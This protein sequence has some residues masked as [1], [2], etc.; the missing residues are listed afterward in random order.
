DKRKKAVG[1]AIRAG[2]K[3]KIEAM[4]TLAQNHLGA[5]PTLFDSDPLL[6]GASNGVVDLRT[7]EHR[8]S[9]RDDYIIKC[10]NADYDCNAT[11]DTWKQFLHRVFDGDT[12]LI[13]FIQRAI[14]Y[15]LTG[16]T[17]EQ[18]L[19]FLFGTGQNGKSTFTKF[20][21]AL[22]GPYALK[23]TSSLYTLAANGR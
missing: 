5:S 1:E 9:R 12:E 2:D 3:A 22:F 19:F 11:C 14:G 16:L 8:P 10:V 17:W 21:E 4:V 13:A 15:S 6:L 23:S 18:C 7:G 20:L